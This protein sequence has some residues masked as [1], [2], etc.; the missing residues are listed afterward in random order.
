MAIKG[1]IFDMDGVIIDSEKLHDIASH[2]FF[3]ARGLV[4]DREFLKPQ[5]MWKWPHEVAAILK[6]HYALE[7][8]I[9][10]MVEEKRERLQKVFDEEL[11]YVPGFLEY[12]TFLVAQWIPSVIATWS[13]ARILAK[14]DSKLGVKN[15][16]W[17]NIITVD[18]VWNV[19][20]PNPALFLGAAK[21]LWLDPVDC[22]II[23][24]ATNGIVAAK[25]AW[26]KVIG[27]TTTLWADVLATVEPD[28]IVSSFDDIRYVT[29]TLLSS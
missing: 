25:A 22:L 6:K 21:L 16:F 9:D 19:G 29:D 17:E 4:Y 26:S 11:E 12:H 24:D 3:K 10:S 1:V 28:Y 13:T 27:L 14:V 20:K 23:E 7:D 2:E 15:I 5:L 8:S 18:Q